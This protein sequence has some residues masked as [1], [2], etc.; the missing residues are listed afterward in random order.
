M[1]RLDN[2]FD[3]I[4][5]VENLQAADVI[6]QKGKSKQLS[7]I[8]HNANQGENIQNLHHALLNKTFTTS[9]YTHFTIKDP[10]KRIIYRLPYYPDRIVQHA[11]MLHLEPMFVSTFTADTYSCIKGRGIIAGVKKLEKALKDKEGTKY[12]LQLD[13]KQ[14][15]PSVDNTI[16]KQLIR[17]KIKDENLLW[18]LDNI[19]NSAKGLPIGNYLSQYLANFY[20]TYFDHWL[21]ETKGVKYYFRYADDM[22]ILSNSKEHL[23]QIRADIKEYLTINLKLE[24]KSNYQV[25]PVASRGIDFLGYIS[26]HGH[27]LLR[28]S[29]KKNFARMMR[30][31]RNIQSIAGYK[32]WLKHCNGKNLFKKLAA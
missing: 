3:Q 4:C 10:K 15:Y 23:H 18:L 14:F 32:G 8:Q 16:L 17:R 31:R 9:E 5:S 29:I 1:K 2:L 26:F 22:V 13:I 30:S 7:V 20:L 25:Y 27:R 19:I 6:A 28:K 24:L 12:C 21:K 11:I